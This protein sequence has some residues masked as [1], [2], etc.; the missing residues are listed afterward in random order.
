[1]TIENA[2]K[3]N[4]L[5]NEDF[6]NENST[7]SSV[8]DLYKKVAEKDPTICKEDFEEYI[9]VI[10]NKM[11]EA[12]EIGETALDDVA[13]GFGWAT[14]A[15]IATGAYYACR[16]ISWSYKAGQAVGEAIYN[17]RH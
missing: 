6:L 17:W 13:G 15:A 7:V 8:E 5:F 16:L 1:M 3:L 11:H 2:E 14:A 9:S 4:N 10:S 12:D